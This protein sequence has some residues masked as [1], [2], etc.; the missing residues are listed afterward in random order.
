MLGDLPRYARHVRG[1]PRKD[2]CVGAEE[3]DEHHF[4]FAVEV[5]A[6]PQRHVVGVTRVEG[7]TPKF[8]FQHLIINLIG[9]N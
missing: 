2:V 7:V 9:F 1:A 3:I 8:K 5:G 4:L 6:D